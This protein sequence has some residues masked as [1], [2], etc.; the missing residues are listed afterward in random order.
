MPRAAKYRVAGVAFSLLVTMAP[1]AARA[2]DGAAAGPRVPPSQSRLFTIGSGALLG[3]TA[4]NVLT[5]PWGTVPLAG[6]ALAGV[7]VTIALGSRLLAVMSAGAGAAVAL[8]VYDRYTGQVFPANYVAS[9][10][11]GGLAGVAAAN[12]LSAGTIGTLPYFAGSGAVAGELASSAAQA[13]SRVYVIGA[14]VMGA[15]VGDYLYRTAGP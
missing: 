6:A 7:P 8:W 4:F 12:L 1:P 2:Q 15:W 14:G 5:A 11:L 10:A 9:L 13:A 3:V